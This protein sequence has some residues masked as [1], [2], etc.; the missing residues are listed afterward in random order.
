MWLF[1][2]LFLD[3]NTPVTI[4][5]G[6]DHSQDI[7]Q[8]MVDPGESAWSKPGAAGASS[9]WNPKDDKKDDTKK[10]DSIADLFASDKKDETDAEA[11]L[12]PEPPKDIALEIGMAPADPSAG[13]SDF[14]IGGD[15]SFDSIPETN[16]VIDG[17]TPATSDLGQSLSVGDVTPQ[18]WTA[19]LT[20]SVSTPP[21]DVS[22]TFLGT[23]PPAP[24][25][26]TPIN[27]TTDAWTSKEES[28]TPVTPPLNA[29]ES[30]IF[31]LI[32]GSSDPAPALAPDTA[33][34]TPP[35]DLAPSPIVS[36][37]GAPAAAAT[38]SSEVAQDAAPK[39]IP[40]IGNG[41]P[42]STTFDQG[43]LT[44]PL[45]ALG[46]YGS[47]SPEMLLGREALALVNQSG[48]GSGFLR[49]KLFSFIEELKALHS[50]DQSQ[51]YHKLE[52]IAMYEERI[53]E[54]DAEAANRKRVLQA[55]IEDL[56]RQI[57]MMD[58]EKNDIQGVISAF[59][60]EI[61]NG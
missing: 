55:E 54:I 53:R 52:Q 14:D 44:S 11:R 2:N 57:E 38:L 35:S 3:Q 24:D 49:E 29:S 27:V 39:G 6:V 32:G 9:G 18:A 10:D 33:L 58:R 61:G 8:V 12:N 13:V 34:A 47:L 16:I 22:G 21:A 1:D 37:I 42:L 5:D 56:K 60:K 7:V 26:P 30:N 46:S 36:D 45:S 28:P 48:Q 19:D 41:N 4:N 17:A 40:D 23:T 50:R 15:I 43:S 59:H 20:A 51:R 31:D 25:A